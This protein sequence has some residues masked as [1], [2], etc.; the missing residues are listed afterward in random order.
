MRARVNH[1]KS[2]V[3]ETYREVLLKELLR[4]L[5]VSVV[6][7]LPVVVIHIIVERVA[8]EP[9]EDIRKIFVRLDV[10]MRVEVLLA[11]S[12]PETNHLRMTLKILYALPVVHQRASHASE[13]PLHVKIA[14]LV[15]VQGMALNLT[16]LYE[17]SHVL[18]SPVQER[19]VLHIPPATVAVRPELLVAGVSLAPVDALALPDAYKDVVLDSELLQLSAAVALEHSRESAPEYTMS[20]I[21]PRTTYL[22]PLLHTVPN[23]IG[24][25]YGR[26]PMQRSQ[27]V[28]APH[29]S[30]LAQLYQDIG[31]LSA[32]NGN[33]QL[34]VLPR[35]MPVCVT[36]KKRTLPDFLFQFLSHGCKSTA[37]KPNNQEKTKKPSEIAQNRQILAWWHNC[38]YRA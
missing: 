38:P 17:L 9:L 19:I 29:P 8:H 20:K 27:T 10:W 34:L 28:L 12:A 25:V 24:R 1:A 3:F 31:V 22:N 5:P 7:P 35:R 15:V 16:L 26:N 23:R 21:T 36:Y 6:L 14:V 4:R 18:V 11:P 33:L 13:T 2:Q 32:T 37:F 30:H